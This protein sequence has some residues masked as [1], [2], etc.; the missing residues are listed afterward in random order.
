MMKDLVMIKIF[1]T[2][3]GGCFYVQYC[4]VLLAGLYVKAV[5]AEGFE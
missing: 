2:I 1:Y 4:P 5:V 3:G